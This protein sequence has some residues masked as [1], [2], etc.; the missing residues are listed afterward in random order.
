MANETHRRLAIVGQPV[1]KQKPEVR[2][3]N[4]DET[5]LGFELATAKVEAMRCI[6]C[7][8]APCQKACPV[9]NDIPGALRL[10]ELGDV[11]GAQ[12]P[13]TAQAAQ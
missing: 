8:D 11:I 3:R 10:L 13:S 4:W 1:R 7:P 9:S 5:F 12:L 2:V 6:Q